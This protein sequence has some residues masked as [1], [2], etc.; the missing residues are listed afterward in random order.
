MTNFII[1]HVPLL[2]SQAKLAKYFSERQVLNE[3]SSRVQD[4]IVFPKHT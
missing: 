2:T 4:T 1:L 3:I